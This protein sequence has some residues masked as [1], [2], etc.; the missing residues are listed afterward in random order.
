MAEL[1]LKVGEQFLKNNEEN[2]AKRTGTGQEDVE[3][4][5]TKQILEVLDFYPQSLENIMLAL[6]E[7]FRIEMGREEITAKIMYLC[8]MGILRQDTQGWY[9]KNR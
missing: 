4:S 3:D 9:S 8:I 1:K 5:F 2:K 6:K 7:R